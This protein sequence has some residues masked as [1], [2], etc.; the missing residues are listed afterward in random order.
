MGGV[1]GGGGGGGGHV[2]YVDVYLVSKLY[3]IRGSMY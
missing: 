3:G 2:H 1:G